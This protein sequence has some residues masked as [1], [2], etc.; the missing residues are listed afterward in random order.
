MKLISRPQE[1]EQSVTM[2]KLKVALVLIGLVL[3][4]ASQDVV[5]QMS[6]TFA[7]P[8]ELCRKEVSLFLINC[9]IVGIFREMMMMLNLFSAFYKFVN[10][11]K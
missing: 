7:K 1:T 4:E 11:I 6:K 9:T 2:I 3:T 8:M 5:M 10:V